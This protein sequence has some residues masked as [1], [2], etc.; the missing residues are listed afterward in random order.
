[1][2]QLGFEARSQESQ[3]HFVS[4]LIEVPIPRL[5]RNL[6]LWVG[7]GGPRRFLQV[8]QSQMSQLQPMQ[9]TYELKRRASPLEA[10]VRAALL[11][12]GL[13]NLPP[14]GAESCYALIRRL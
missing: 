2:L 10:G 6:A 3:S 7:S 11:A 5:R 9:I 8:Q 1:M 13:P 4:D 12:A 14:A